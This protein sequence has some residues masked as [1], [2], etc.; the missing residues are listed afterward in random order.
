MATLLVLLLAVPAA[1]LV[2]LVAL[3]ARQAARVGVIEPPLS[4]ERDSADHP[5][6]ETLEAQC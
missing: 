6:A 2:V 4:L 3:S 1:G 5:H